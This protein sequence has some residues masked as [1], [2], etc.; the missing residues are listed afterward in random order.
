MTYNISFGQ[1]WREFVHG[2]IAC[3]FIGLKQYS[4]GQKEPLLILSVSGISPNVT[5]YVLGITTIETNSTFHKTPV[6]NKHDP[7]L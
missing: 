7:S 5:R 2:L 3:N 4:Y 6:S 1:C